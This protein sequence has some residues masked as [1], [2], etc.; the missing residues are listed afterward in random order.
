MYTNKEYEVLEEKMVGKT[1]RLEHVW[2]I[3]LSPAVEYELNV[4]GHCGTG[5][6][7]EAFEVSYASS[8]EGPYKR[9]LTMNSREDIGMT[10][11]MNISGNILYLKIEDS[12]SDCNDTELDTF[13]TDDV[14]VCSKSSKSPYATGDAKN[15]KWGHTNFGLYGSSFVGIFGGIIETTN[16]EGIL[17]LDC[18][19][20]DYFHSKAYPTYLYYNPHSEK[21]TVNID[22]GTE[23]KGIYDAVENKFLVT[24]A[25]GIQSFSI[26]PDSAVLVVL[27]PASGK[28]KYDGKKTLI[29][30]VVVDYM[31]GK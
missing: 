18:L 28:I 29:D 1:A 2:E 24:D 14:Y 13:Y 5:G 17:K 10:A 19:A 4:T 22:L 25:A 15:S 9:A 27:T 3:S 8:P 16:V 12:N 21:K 11:D 31:N 23:H 6:N 7:G 30:G 26:E 20:T